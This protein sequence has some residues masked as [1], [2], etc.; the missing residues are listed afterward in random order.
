MLRPFLPYIGV[1]LMVLPR[2]DV[3]APRQPII[4]MAVDVEA[5]RI[6]LDERNPKRRM[7]GVLEFMGGWELR[8]S[9]WQFGSLSG[10]VARGGDF[11][12][13]SD[14]GAIV[15]FTLSDTGKV[16][17][18]RVDPLPKGCG[19]PEFKTD[20]DSESIAQLGEGGPVWIATEW[21][22]RMCRLD[23]S[24]S[25]FVR[26]LRSQPMRIWDRKNGAEAMTWLKDGRLAVFAEA[27]PFNKD[28]Q[29]VPLILYQGDPTDPATPYGEAKYQRTPS[30]RPVDAA[31][32]PGGDVLVLER[33]FSLP[34][35][36]ETILSRVPAS[37]FQA[38]QKISGKIIARFSP[39]IVTDNFEAIAVEPS[40]GGA[41]IWIASDDN[42]LFLQ[43]NLLLK[44]W[45]PEKDE[46]EKA[47][48]PRRAIP[49]GAS[50]D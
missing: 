8:P 34:F 2:S 15:R 45:L 39:P 42:Q 18:A 20:Q 43:R 48:A 19:K 21:S 30:Y 25:H 9:H 37:A 5:K 44:F 24:A 7:L 28:A 23:P 32:L 49:G 31:T 6:A 4:A 17:K 33:R 40:K 11:V 36:F 26:A 35:Q 22:N 47:E 1:A 10:F 12:G 38:G 27:D 3:Q 13:V 16:S 46:A 41:I 50:S 29:D 14:Y